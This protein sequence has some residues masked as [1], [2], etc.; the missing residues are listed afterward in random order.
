MHRLSGAPQSDDDLAAARTGLRTL[1]SQF[2]VDLSFSAGN[3][4]DEDLHTK[5]EIIDLIRQTYGFPGAPGSEGH[6][7]IA[8]TPDLSEFDQ[9]I[10]ALIDTDTRGIAAVF[11]AVHPLDSLDPSFFLQVCAHEIGHMLN[12]PHATGS[13]VSIPSAMCQANIRQGKPIA[14]AWATVHLAQPQ[15]LQAYPF[16]EAEGATLIDGNPVRPPW[17]GRFT[18]STGVGGMDPGIQDV[19][20]EPERDRAIVGA[21][22]GLTI[23]VT[24]RG[25]PRPLPNRIEPELGT[26]LLRVTR[27]NGETYDHRPNVVACSFDQE[28]LAQGETRRHSAVLVRGPGGLAFPMAGTYRLEASLDSHR[29]TALE[30][31]AVAGA[32]PAPSNA[33]SRFIAAGAPRRRWRQHKLLNQLLRNGDADRDP[34]VAHLAYLKARQMRANDLAAEL[35]EAV[36]ASRAAPLALRTAAWFERCRRSTDEPARNAAR[37]EDLFD[38]KSFPSVHRQ[39]C[40]WMECT[41]SRQRQRRRRLSDKKEEES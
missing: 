39:L 30:I 3:V 38:E 21:P 31:E 32:T 28:E 18:D 24:N 17:G 8:T 23:E 4:F 15:S 36:A 27:P 9:A 11:G 16:S 7:L 5:A 35:L 12:L 33:F 40:R 29:W 25:R 37:T 26:L 20:L 41:E 19:A 22:L 1:F 13:A 14:A 10:G 2:G 6:L 34:A